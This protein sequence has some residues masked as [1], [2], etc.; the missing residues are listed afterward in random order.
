MRE[1]LFYFLSVHVSVHYVQQK[2]C[3]LQP[4]LLFDSLYGPRPLGKL[5]SIVGGKLARYF[6][7]CRQ[8]VL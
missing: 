5:Y 4:F 6:R 1:I 2:V 3:I 7:V 8:T